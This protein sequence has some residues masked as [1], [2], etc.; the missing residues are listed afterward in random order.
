MEKDPTNITVYRS[1]KYIK[2][3]IPIE[4]LIFSQGRREEPIFIQDEDK[5]VK[6]FM[7]NFLDFGK[8][9]Y[10]NQYGKFFD[11]LDDWFISRLESG[12]LY[13]EGVN[14]DL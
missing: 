5:M 2:I 13:L 4:L 1:K 14:E 3:N 10:G 6:D 11:L 8:G 12:E 7:L 9:D